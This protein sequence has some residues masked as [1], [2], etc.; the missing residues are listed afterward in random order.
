[1]CDDNNHPYAP[2]KNRVLIFLTL[3]R[4]V[5]YVGIVWYIDPI[6]LHIQKMYDTIPYHTIL[7]YHL[8]YD[9]TI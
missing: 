9:G 3:C 5:P 4:V 8:Q 1:M 2:T 6:F 7:Y